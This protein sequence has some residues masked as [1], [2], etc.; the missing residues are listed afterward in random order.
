M[1]ILSAASG[2]SIWRGY[3]YYTEKKVIFMEKTGEDEYKGRVAG[4]LPEPYR[5]TIDTAHIR[6]SKCNCAHAKGT[7]IICKHMVALYFAAFPE[8][9]DAYIAQVEENEREE[10]RQL[11]NHYAEIKSYIKSL[12]KEEL[13]EELFRTLI[14]L[15]EIS[16]SYW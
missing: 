15:E 14:E 9:A 16:G 4:T 5:V 1:G 12:S 6:K 13:Q 2:A 11:Q 3:E 8:E 10:E 7:R